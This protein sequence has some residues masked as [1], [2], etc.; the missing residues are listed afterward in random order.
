MNIYDMYPSNLPVSFLFCVSEPAITG[1][2]YI[3][4]NEK[5]GIF[6][7]D[8]SRIQQKKLNGI[9]DF[10]FLDTTP[11]GALLKCSLSM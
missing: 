4:N 10:F 2:C 3:N 1:E 9:P 6:S 7:F 5:T 11:T 8:A